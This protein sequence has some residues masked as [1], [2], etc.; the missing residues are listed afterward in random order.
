M[1]TEEGSSDAP[2]VCIRVLF[3]RSTRGRRGGHLEVH[4]PLSALLLLSPVSGS[5]FSI[6]LLVANRHT[7]L[8]P[9]V[10]TKLPPLVSRSLLLGSFPVISIIW[11]ALLLS[12]AAGIAKKPS[13][14][15]E[16]PVTVVNYELGVCLS[17]PGAH[18]VRTKT[19]LPCRFTRINRRTFNDFYKYTY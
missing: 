7:L 8:L 1:V 3:A 5:P 17:S 4:L 18:S 11:N 14:R 2:K 9:D 13:P 16:S 6:A 12:T 15:S 19:N 10:F